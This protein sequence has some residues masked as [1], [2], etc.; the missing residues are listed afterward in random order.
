MDLHPDYPLETERLLLRPFVRGDVDAVHAYRSRED[1]T[2][3]MHDGPMSREACAEAVQARVSM[4]SWLEEGDKLFL[5]VERKSD[6]AMMGEV[7]LI[8]RSVT[9]R[10]AELGYTFH[11][12]Y[13]G[14]GYATEAGRR[15][16]AL[17]FGL[18][19]MHRIYA[20]CHALNDASRR[21]MQRL[22]MRQEAHFRGHS[23]VKGEW[24]EELVFAILEDEWREQLDGT[25][26]PAI[27]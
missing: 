16:L 14:N 20:R 4:V 1:V 8:L 18:G 22:G 9:S 27:G 12:N 5:A 6:A 26:P 19:G 13:F 21:V 10:Q 2:R 15:L 23:L 11:P 7:V 24:D 17:G 25:A 3:F